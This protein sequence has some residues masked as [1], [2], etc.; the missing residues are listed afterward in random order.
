MR[1]IRAGKYRHFKGGEYEVISTAQH[2]ESSETVVV[3]RPLYGEKK[4]W[5]RPIEMFYD[6]KLLNGK[7]VPRF[8]FLEEMSH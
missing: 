5:V 8:E 4:L 1:E 2:S 3:Y 6:M 7:E